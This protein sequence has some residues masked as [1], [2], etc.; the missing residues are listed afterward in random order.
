MGKKKNRAATRVGVTAVAGEVVGNVAG[1]LLA[2]GAEK[3][4][5]R[6]KADGRKDAPRSADAGLLLLLALESRRPRRVAD[7]LAGVGRRAGVS[8]AMEAMRSARELGLVRLQ[9][10]AGARVRLTR[11]GGETDEV[12]RASLV[13]G[14]GKKK[15]KKR[16][17]AGDAAG[18]GNEAA[19][20]EAAG[21]GQNG[22]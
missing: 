2:D 10:K 20:L 13:E 17:G 1:Q 7:L 12:L 9:G 8:A 22:A 21:A 18:D 16:S 11:L 19:I 3:L 6:F 4:L 14:G 15:K 5:A